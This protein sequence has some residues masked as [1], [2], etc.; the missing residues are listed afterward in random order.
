MDYAQETIEH[1]LFIK[2]KFYEVYESIE[3]I[4][5]EGMLIKF[6]FGH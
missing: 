2:I 5:V 4:F 6:V 1:T 3:W